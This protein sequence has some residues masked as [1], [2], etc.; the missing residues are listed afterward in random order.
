MFT[1]QRCG[2]MGGQNMLFFPIEWS[3]L[4]VGVIFT[5]FSTLYEKGFS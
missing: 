4:P 2:G 5:R 3:I 1:M